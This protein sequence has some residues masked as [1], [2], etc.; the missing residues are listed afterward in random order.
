MKRLHP[1]IPIDDEGTVSS[2]HSKTGKVSTSSKATG[3]GKT[4]I[5]D[6]VEDGP[7]DRFTNKDPTTKGGAQKAIQRVIYECI[8]DLGFPSSTVEKPVFHAV[9]ETVHQ[10]AK[11][12]RFGNK[13]QVT[14][15]NS[16]T[17]LQQVCPI[18]I[19]SHP[20]GSYTV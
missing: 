12:Q 14:F 2:K 11:N 18:Y 13:Q 7:L 19:N 3:V 1:E 17:I 8:N 4:A 16:T 9:L 6:F 10:N 20:Q 5:I 15:I